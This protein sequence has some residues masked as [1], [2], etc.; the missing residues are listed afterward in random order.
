VSELSDRLKKSKKEVPVDT[1]KITAIARLGQEGQNGGVLDLTREDFANEVVGHLRKTTCKN[2]TDGEIA[3]VVYLAQKY[4]FDPLLGEVGF[5]AG[6]GPW[7]S[8]DARLQLATKQPDYG[9]I[10]SLPVYDKNDKLFAWKC[11]GYKLINGNRIPVVTMQHT[12]SEWRKD[13]WSKGGLNEEAMIQKTV[14]DRVFERMYPLSG[15]RTDTQMLPPN[16]PNTTSSIKAEYK[17]PAIEVQEAQIED[18]VQEE[19]TTG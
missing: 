13:R 15:V 18:V 19:E 6:Q 8:R 11:T 14:E 9:G 1:D 7:I 16:L 3:Q 10:D 2:C 17:P 5:I 12:L 4:D